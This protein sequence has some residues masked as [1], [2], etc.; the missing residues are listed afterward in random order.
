[1]TYEVIRQCNYY[2]SGTFQE[3]GTFDKGEEVDILEKHRGGYN[4]ATWGTFE[5]DGHTYDVLIRCREWHVLKLKEDKDVKPNKRSRKGSA[6]R[7]S[8]G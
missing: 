1:M 7:D 8:E 6:G 4:G 2:R 5:K 3:A